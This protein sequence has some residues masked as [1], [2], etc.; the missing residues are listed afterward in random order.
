MK[1]ATLVLLL[2]A[3]ATPSFSF[4]QEPTA[5]A[6]N[7]GPRLVLDRAT[8]ARLFEAESI[9]SSAGSR[10]RLLQQANTAN[11]AAE[12]RACE[13]CPRRRVA[14]AYFQAAVIN[15]IYN[16]GNQ[17]RGE[18]TAKISFKSWWN[19]MK[20]GFEWDD[21]PF[22]TNQ[23]GHPYQGSNYYT[24]GRANGMSY[25]ES[26]A[27]TAFGSATWEYF[28]ENNYASFNDLVNTTLG[29]IALGEAF[30]RAA[31]MIRDTHATGKK[32]LWQEIAGTAVD[33]MGGFNRFVSGDASR[34]SDKPATFRPASSTAVGSV[35]ALWQ[36][37][38]DN[39]FS[40]S[41]DPFLEMDLVYGKPL[42]GRGRTPFE[43]FTVNFRMGGGQGLSDVRVRGR[44]FG[45]PVDHGKLHLALAHSFDYVANR[46]YKFG[47]QGFDFV[48]SKRIGT[49][50]G[51][52]AVILGGAGVTAQGAIDRVPA[53][54]PIPEVPEGEER[55]YDYGPGTAFGGTATFQRN[56]RTFFDVAYQGFQIYVV[57][58]VRSN[59]VLQR[60]RMDLMVPVHRR[61]ALGTA[62]EYF[63][64]KTYFTSGGE[65]RDKFPQVRIFLAWR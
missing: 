3:L 23:F 44:L 5:P 41:P 59:H 28:G 26:A 45:Q 19:N 43:A 36:G 16:I 22:V 30:H 14:A 31:W 13:G 62:G 47:R 50:E 11:W 37:D 6:A 10:E 46:A 58:G 64:R 56:G 49:I 33:P 24:A 34:V 1:L 40:E 8:M 65:R 52:S 7:D 32:R 55:D 54:G 29:G 2:F 38:N 17:V 21:N 9:D 60:F 57:D 63:Y 15:V 61:L 39:A 27:L 12:G 18:H 25:W 51:M 53:E 20:Y 4:A 42:E 35:G 48:L